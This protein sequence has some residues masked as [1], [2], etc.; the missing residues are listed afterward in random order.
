MESKNFV[1]SQ[2]E[3]ILNMFQYLLVT[4]NYY[5]QFNT[6]KPK[7]SECK[8]VHQFAHHH[9]ISKNENIRDIRTV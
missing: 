8:P 1:I 5:S 2:A 7:T 4:N 6:A 9:T 3:K